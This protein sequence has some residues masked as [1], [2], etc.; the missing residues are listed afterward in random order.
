MFFS[1]KN[2]WQYTLPAILMNSTPCCEVSHQKN[3][4]HG[5][6]VKQ[7]PGYNSIPLLHRVVIKSRILIS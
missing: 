4:Q 3:R 2:F 7:Y 6:F 5:D 1:G